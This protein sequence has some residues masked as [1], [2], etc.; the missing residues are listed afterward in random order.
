MK[1]CAYRGG[2]G[3]GVGGNLHE[4]ISN[5]IRDWKFSR[6]ARVG[7]EVAAAV[8]PQLLLKGLSL[9]RNEICCLHCWQIWT[10]NTNLIGFSDATQ[11]SYR[12]C[13]TICS[14]S[15]I[16]LRNSLSLVQQQKH[17]LCLMPWCAI[18]TLFKQQMLELL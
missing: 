12:P 6:L 16:N 5:L 18:F 15:K 17:P 14:Y 7:L 9:H 11:T 4:V 10:T 1:F 2:G 3:V 13:P 8:Q